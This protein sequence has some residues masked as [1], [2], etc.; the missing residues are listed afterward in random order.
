LYLISSGTTIISD[1]STSIVPDVTVSTIE[2]VYTSVSNTSIP[3]TFV[4]TTGI[5]GGVGGNGTTTTGGGAGGGDGTPS[6]TQT[7]GG[8]STS[9]PAAA[10]NIKVPVQMGGLVF[11][12]LIAVGM[13]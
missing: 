3:T 2:S 4:S 11:A 5:V 9:S 13:L 7:G 8:S 12:V 10:A 1:G 6:E